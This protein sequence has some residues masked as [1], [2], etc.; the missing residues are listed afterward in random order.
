MRVTS[1]SFSSDKRLSRCEQQYSY[2]AD[3]RLK[4]RLKGK[5][6]YMGDWIHELLQAYRLKKDWKKR[7]QEFKKEKWDKL[8]DEEK[9]KYEEDGL[10]PELVYALFEHYVDHWSEQDKHCKVIQVEKS[11]ELM[12]KYGFPVRWKSDYIVQDGR[13]VVLFENKNKK[14]IPDSSERILSPQ[15][16]A[17]CYL[18]SKVG[19]KV[20]RIT[21][22]YIRTE[23][24]PSPQ[25]LKSG[26]LSKRKINTDQRTYLKALKE[27]KIHPKGDEVIG[28]QNYLET[29]PE[30]LSLARV[31]NAPNL[32][33]GEQFVRDWIE[34]HRRAQLIKRPLR[35]WTRSCSWDCDYYTLCSADMLGNVDR[36]MIIKK[37]FI[38]ITGRNGEELK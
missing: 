33:V 9:E 27:A 1:C 29:L 16:H 32:K 4:P 34:R 3:Q 28:L 12:T 30:T 18:L 24:V 37:D 2:R 10:T 35:T 21:W 11:Y 7:F 17:Y 23:P 5:G 8:F 38:Q 13:A 19:I 31:T 25:I 20:N 15:V 26:E 22:D 14:E 36:N 6:L